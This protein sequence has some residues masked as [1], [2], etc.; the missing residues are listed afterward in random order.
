MG[1]ILSRPKLSR[2]RAGIASLEGAYDVPQAGGANQVFD[3]IWDGG[4]LMAKASGQPDVEL[5]PKSDRLFWASQAGQMIGM[6]IEF[7]ED[8]RQV[9]MQVSTPQSSQPVTAARVSL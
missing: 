2:S 7:V 8:S 5:V 1:T 9:E 4:K 6:T 3:I